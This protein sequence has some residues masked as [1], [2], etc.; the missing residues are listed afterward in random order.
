MNLRIPGPTPCPPEV[1]QAMGRQM[2]NHRGPEFRALLVNVLSR[3]KKIYQTEGEV[4][5]FTCSGTGGME[6]AIVNTM[7][8]GDHVL[9]VTN[10]SFGDRFA[11]IATEFGGQVIKLSF[12]WGDPVDHQAVTRALKDDPSI[13]LVLVTHN[14][15]STGVTNDLEA[16]GAAVREQGRLL[17]VDAVSSLGAIDLPMDEWGCDVVVT[18]SQKSW[19]VPPGLAMVAVSKRAWK[20][21]EEA[22]SPRFYWDFRSMKRFQDN[23]E[24]PFTP[25]ISVYFALAAALDAMEKEGFANVVARHARVGAYTRNM[26][27]GLGLSLFPNED[28]ASNT[29][30]AIRAP[31]GVDVKSL[32]RTLREQHEVVLAGG[33]G[34]LDGRIF[35][36]G[37]LGYVS[38]ADI[39]VVREAL[40]AVLPL[41]ASKG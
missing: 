31:E 32:L 7:S 4:L 23:G 22:S 30:T 8:P 10:G 20:A 2:I 14:E 36:V 19:M 38:E 40:R 39:D 21:V 26:V 13:K 35:R 6:A 25:A 3:I 12:E 1:L 16:I 18:G 15:T 37:H 29:V 17:L 9:S 11:R 28:Y 34:K 27:K 41:E 33:Q 5:I 24:T